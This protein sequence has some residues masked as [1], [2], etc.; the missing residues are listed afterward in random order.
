[1]TFHLRSRHLIVYDAL[2]IVAA[3]GL[4]FVIR[5]DTAYIWNELSRYWAFVVPLLLVKIVA[6]Y[7]F[8]L[9]R[10]IW[11]YASTPEMVG[12]VSAVSLGSAAA[13]VGLIAAIGPL[14]MPWALGFPRGVVAIDFLLSI[15][16]IGGGRFLLRVLSEAQTA[17]RREATNSHRNGGSQA[18][19]LIVGAGDA[20]AL[21]VRELRANQSLGVQPV[22]FVDDDAR[23]HGHVIHGVPVLGSLPQLPELLQSHG[24]SEVVIAMPTAGGRVIREI[25]Q[26]CRACG[27]ASKTVPGLYEL[28][29]G[30]ASLKQFR[31]VTISD[32]L[33][34]EQVELPT[35]RADEL[36]RGRVVMVTGAG[37]SIGSELCRQVAAFHPAR[38]ILLGHGEFSLFQIERELAA[39]HPEIPRDTVVADVKD[40]PR[41]DA[42]F[43]R[44]RPDVVFHAAA[45]KHVVLMERNAAEAVAT[46]VLGTLNIAQAAARH[47]SSRFVLI[48]TDKAVCPRN[49]YGAT[50]RM[51]EMVV[52]SMAQRHPRTI[53]ATVRFGNVLG[54]R[55]S[56]VPIFQQQIAAG[57][58]ITITDPA[59]TRYFMTVP[60]AVQL[61]L[62]SAALATDGE[63]FV[64]DMGE[65]VRIAD[66][67]RDLVELSGLQLGRDIEL[68]VVGLGPGES[69]HEELVAPNEEA[70]PT[71][72]AKVQRLSRPRIDELQI[73]RAVAQ[74]EAV[75]LV[76]DADDDAVRAELQSVVPDAQLA[77]GAGAPLSLAFESR[78]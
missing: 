66:L 25:S 48:S 34:R 14:G 35:E 52:Q 29:S 2:A 6:L 51:A 10:R 65:P 47:G 1:M 58:P 19:A 7:W 55:G 46:N 23:K 45:H 32:L 11:R 39:S 3:Y 24:V 40:R 37:G 62:Q 57:G 22:G 59:A 60:E 67:A 30:N 49:V 77:R 42:A 70:A 18:R 50:K 36:V 27:V 68:R 76:G 26:V 5:F 63:L 21:V 53:F 78:A 44:H 43:D 56:V 8:G 73:R 61:V 20:G 71:A 12:L 38:I 17:R 16:L 15:A 4:A 13:G 33:R 31:D 72:V 54:S 75:V 9:Y 69:L 74:L 64:L 41:V 28:I